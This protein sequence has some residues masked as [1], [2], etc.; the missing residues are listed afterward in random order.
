MFSIQDGMVSES[1][2]GGAEIDIVFRIVGKRAPDEGAATALC[3]ALRWLPAILPGTIEVDSTGGSGL[4][5]RMVGIVTIGHYL[6]RSTSQ[7]LL[8]A[9]KSRLQLTIIDGVCGCLHIDHQ[10]VGGVGY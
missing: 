5:R 7:G 6:F 9:I 1:L 2:S 3:V 8:A 10:P 4:H